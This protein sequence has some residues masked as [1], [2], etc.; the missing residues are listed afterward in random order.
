MEYPQYWRYWPLCTEL[1]SS[2]PSSP[3]H[4]S[5][6]CMCPHLQGAQGFPGGT[7]APFGLQDCPALPSSGVHFAPGEF[8]LHL[9]PGLLG[10]GR[11]APAQLVFARAGSLK[12]V[13][14]VAAAGSSLALGAGTGTHVPALWRFA[15]LCPDLL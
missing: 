11:K 5:P 2:Q 6:C 8:R 15:L 9:S 4:R 13:P 12:A 14:A 10:R 3:C 7:E 1:G